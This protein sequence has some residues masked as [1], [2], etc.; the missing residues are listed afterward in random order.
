MWRILFKEIWKM[1]KTFPPAEHPWKGRGDT[2][3]PG[4]PDKAMFMKMDMVCWPRN[5]LVVKC[6]E[7]PKTDGFV[8]NSV[9]NNFFTP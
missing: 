7:F 5:C 2:R 4:T 8:G 3:S 6:G 1:E 9:G